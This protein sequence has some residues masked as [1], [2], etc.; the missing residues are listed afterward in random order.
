MDAFMDA[1]IHTSELVPALNVPSAVRETRNQARNEG[2][3]KS[4][5]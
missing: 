2:E 4:R 5:D 1:A 3:A